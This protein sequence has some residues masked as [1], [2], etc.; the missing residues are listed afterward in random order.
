MATY[1]TGEDGDSYRVSA[2]PYL[3]HGPECAQVVYGVLLDHVE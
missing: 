2:E 1:L 3:K